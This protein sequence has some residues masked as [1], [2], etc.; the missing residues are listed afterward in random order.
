[1]VNTDRVAGIRGTKARW[2]VE[3]VRVG[4]MWNMKL[5]VYAPPAVVGKEVR[6]LLGGGIG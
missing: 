4:G 6:L 3:M 1:M 2:G 5:G